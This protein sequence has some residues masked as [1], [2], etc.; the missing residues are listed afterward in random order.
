[1]ADMPGILR[2]ATHEQEQVRLYITAAKQAEATASTQLALAATADTPD[3]LEVSRQSAQED[4]ERLTSSLGVGLTSRITLSVQC[5]S[6][7]C[8]RLSSQ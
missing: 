5:F 2:A 6:H 1:M 4:D 7:H 8:L 3:S